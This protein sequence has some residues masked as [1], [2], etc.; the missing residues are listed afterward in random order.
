MRRTSLIPAI[1]GI[2]VA[3]HG[4]ATGP[5]T[6]SLA[7][8]V[9]SDQAAP[10][11]GARVIAVDTANPARADTA[12]TDSVGHYAFYD[13][14]SGTR[15]VSV[16]SGSLPGGCFPPAAARAAIAARRTTPLSFSV[17]CVLVAG[18]YDGYA[19]VTTGG[20]A[21]AL[22][23]VLSSLGVA[24]FFPESVAFTLKVQQTDSVFGMDGSYSTG[25]Y[26]GHVSSGLVLIEGPVVLS[27]LSLVVPP[28]T[29]TVG[30]PPLSYSITVT[31][32]CQPT[33]PQDLQV[34]VDS[35]G[36]GHLTAIRGNLPFGCTV[37]VPNLGDFYGT[38]DFH[39]VVDYTGP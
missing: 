10:I 1:A 6:P 5:R 36:S 21:A 2:V 22:D 25:L 31:T 14:G 18:A 39:V 20:A 11:V 17:N 37:S 19:T 7:G 8:T 33:A 28:V 12:A 35:G 30:T 27:Q 26:T 23:T 29:V 34:S 13:L 24:A 9:F 32:T 16:T 38:F 3:C 4:D 15:T